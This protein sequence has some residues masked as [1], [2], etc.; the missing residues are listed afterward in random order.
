MSVFIYSERRRRV[1]NG[2]YFQFILVSALGRIR[3]VDVRRL[4]DV[5]SRVRAHQECVGYLHEEHRAVFHRWY[6]FLSVRIQ[7]HVR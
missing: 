1:G 2:F 4:Y 5:G 6:H 3:H 7:P